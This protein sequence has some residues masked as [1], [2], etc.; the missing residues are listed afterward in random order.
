VTAELLNEYKEMIKNTTADLIELL[1]GIDDKIESEHS[2]VPGNSASDDDFGSDENSMEEERASIQQCLRICDEVSTHIGQVLA[3]GF[4]D[5]STPSGDHDRLIKLG[6]VTPARFTTSTT[7]ENCKLG[8]GVTSSQLKMQLDEINNRMARLSQQAAILDDYAPGNQT[9]KEEL[10]SIKECLAIC[11]KATEQVTKERVHVFED[12]EMADDGQQVIV[13][14]MGD[15]ISA[16]RITAGARSMQWLGQ[17]S[18]ASLQQLSKAHKGNAEGAGQH[19][20]IG[21]H[22]EGRHGSGRKLS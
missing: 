8:L 21:A 18:D 7:L 16:K 11:T 5:I 22:F 4:A 2:R 13:A 6:G 15:L 9:L 19:T 14:T 17:M 10:D 20:E 3:N 1:H 12:V